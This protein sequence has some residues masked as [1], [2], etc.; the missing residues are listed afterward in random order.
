MDQGEQ[1]SSKSFALC[2]TSA[3]VEDEPLNIVIEN[4]IFTILKMFS[5]LFNL[6]NFLLQIPKH[7]SVQCVVE[8]LFHTRNH[9]LNIKNIFQKSS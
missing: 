7:K 4:V 9:S 6:I 3:Q 1:I 2:K 5:I 8:Q